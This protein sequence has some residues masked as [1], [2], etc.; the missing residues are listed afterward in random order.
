MIRS[1]SPFSSPS[2]WLNCGYS[3]MVTSSSVRPPASSSA[4]SACQD[5]PK[6]PGRP[7]AQARQ[8]GRLGRH[9]LRRPDQ[10]HRE[11]AVQGRHVLD[12]DAGGAAD[13]HVGRIGHPELGLAVRHQ[14]DRRRRC[15]RWSRPARHRRRGRPAAP[16]RRARTGRPAGSRAAASPAAGRPGC[17]MAR[18]MARRSGSA[19]RQP[20]PGRGRGS[21]WRGGAWTSVSFRW[22]GRRDARPSRPG[23]RRPG[24]GWRAPRGRRT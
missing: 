2:T 10:R 16:G 23:C 22:C 9:R 12:R 8:L 18:W 15:T 19:S 4:S 21:G 3:R 5:E 24:P 6:R 13:H 7:D 20:A 11:V 14:A 17:R 1:T